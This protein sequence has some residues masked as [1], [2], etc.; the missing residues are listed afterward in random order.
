MTGRRVLRAV[1]W[2]LVI[3]TAATTS[4]AAAVPFSGGVASA[5]GIAAAA[6]VLLAGLALEPRKERR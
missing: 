4:I 6:A 3:L 5:A 2:P 1:Y